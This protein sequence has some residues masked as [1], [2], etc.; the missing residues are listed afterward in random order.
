MEFTTQYLYDIEPKDLIGRE[1][2]E[3]LEFKLESAKTL[4]AYLF[5]HNKD[6]DRQHYVW[7]AKEHTQKL[8]DELNIKE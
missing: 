3:A 5:I 6:A 8:L 4:F 7:K 1:Y 2:K